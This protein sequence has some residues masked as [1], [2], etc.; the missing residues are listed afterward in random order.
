MAKRTDK[1]RD[2][3]R[4]EVEAVARREFP[5]AREYLPWVHGDLD[6]MVAVWHAGDPEATIYRLPREALLR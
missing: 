4:E 2:G 1:L 5:D 3:L 6:P